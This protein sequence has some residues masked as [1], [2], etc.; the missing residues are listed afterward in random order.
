MSVASAPCAATDVAECEALRATATA[1]VV[2]TSTTLVMLAMVHPRIPRRESGRFSQGMCVA[3]TG[4]ASLANPLGET[5]GRIESSSRAMIRAVG[6]NPEP[7]QSWSNFALRY[8]PRMFSN[9][10]ARP[11]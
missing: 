5:T 3:S 11:E 6:A 8:E 2:P 9:A 4:R 1:T 7:E 10:S